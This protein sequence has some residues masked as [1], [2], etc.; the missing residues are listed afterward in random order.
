MSFAGSVQFDLLW[1]P[2]LLFGISPDFAKQSLRSIY[3]NSSTSSTSDVP[4]ELKAR[5]SAGITAGGGITFKFLR[6]RISPELRYTHWGNTSF[7]G[8]YGRQGFHSY[9][10]QADLIVGFA[11]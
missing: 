5:N 7:A 8:I 3:P 4:V 6:L 9:S 10:D 1:M 2:V 11:F